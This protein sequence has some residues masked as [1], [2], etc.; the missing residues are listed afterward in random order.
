MSIEI[1]DTFKR[2][3]FVEKLLILLMDLLPWIEKDNDL[4]PLINLDLDLLILNLVANPKLMQLLYRYPNIENRLLEIL[5]DCKI[6]I[7]RKNIS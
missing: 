5:T 1:Q 2:S 7:I 3:Q 4:I 6:E